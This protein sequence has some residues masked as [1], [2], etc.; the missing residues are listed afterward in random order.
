MAK[1]IEMP[2]LGFDMAEGTL[3]N[4]IIAEGEKVEKGE[5]LAEIETDTRLCQDQ[6]IDTALVGVAGIGAAVVAV[7]LQGEGDRHAVIF[8]HAI[9]KP[10]HTVGARLVVFNRVLFVPQSMHDHRQMRLG[11][12]DVLDQLSVCAVVLGKVIRDGRR[13]EVPVHKGL[14]VV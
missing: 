9:D 14:H 12:L 1:I 5:V 2:K 8:E 4:W 11:I 6:H 7:D 10:H 13:G 3:I